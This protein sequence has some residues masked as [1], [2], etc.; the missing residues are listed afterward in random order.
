MVK[1][2]NNSFLNL[3]FNLIIPII[4]LTRFSGDEYLGARLGL[5]IA[6]LFPLFYGIIEF[7][8]DKKIN[9]FSV[10][11]IVSV[12][13]T[14]AIGLLELP[15]SLLALKEAGIP[16]AIGV[17]LVIL[18]IS[19][20]SVLEELLKDSFDFEKIRKSLKGKNRNDVERGIVISNYLLAFVFFLSAVANFVL[21]K[22]IVKSP[23]GTTEYAAEI[24]YL[25]GISFIVILLPF[26]FSFI[27]IVT[28]LI[29]YIMKKT[30]LGIDEISYE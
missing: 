8:K 11:G 2:K 13:L 4:I 23:P 6:L 27:L 10:L 19:G 17:F 7:R 12:I 9:F 26:L 22:V 18:Q 14:G 29:F 25:N 3:V 28:L 16:F 30:G 24:G 20:Y 1:K 15:T 21:T 5:V